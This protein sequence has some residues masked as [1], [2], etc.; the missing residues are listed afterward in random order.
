MNNT[1]NIKE[2][3]LLIEMHYFILSNILDVILSF[4]ILQI[5]LN[6]F[7]EKNQQKKRT[8]L[9][10]GTYLGWQSIMTSL[11]FPIAIKLCV[12]VSL[13]ILICC[14]GYIGETLTKIIFAFMISV[15]WTLMEFII[16]NLLFFFDVDINLINFWGIL[17]SKILV[18]LLVKILHIFFRDENISGFP[19]KYA[20]ILLIGIVG[21]MIIVYNVFSL[22]MSAGV[23]IT[24][25]ISLGILLVINIMNFRIYFKL[26]EDME[27]RTQNVVYARQLKLCT[28]HNKE[29]EIMWT[30]FRNAKHDMKQHFITLIKYLEEN[31]N[32]SAKKYLKEI[33]GDNRLQEI[34]ISK[35][36][37]IIVDAI[38][39]AKFAVANK[40]N[41]NFNSQINVPIQLPFENGDIS[42]LLGNI[43]DN[44]IE[45]CIK[46]PSEQR[47]VELVI[48]YENN[49]L[50]IVC[51]NNYNGQLIKG[52]EGE[53]RTDKRDSQNHG[54]GLRSIKKI[55]T[56]YHGSVVY[57]SVETIFTLRA[58]LYDLGK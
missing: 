11:E 48:R 37:N 9:C 14:I 31:D 17:L 43:L 32:V 38:V 47:K 51:R 42:I 40:W 29:K 46:V 10:W 57:D 15:L 28:V 52:K 50:L 25:L 54:I 26:A 22:S 19:T 13:I 20:T 44:A 3:K 34:G 24:P 49:M 23:F 36:D 27:I 1:V 18:L 53:L 8:L 35:S 56:K 33:I 58:T 5:Y 55:A 7:F 12:S 4:I 6:T 2:I 41:I 30:E 45:A 21:N 16:G 39:N